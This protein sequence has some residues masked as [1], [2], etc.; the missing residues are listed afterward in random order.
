[1]QRQKPLV[2][3]HR[4]AAG[5][6]PENTLAAFSRA[7]SLG[8][9]AVE[10]DVLMTA[11]DVL[12][13]HHNFTLNPSYSRTSDGTWIPEEG[14]PP[15]R[16]L[17]LEEIKAYDVGRLKPG[18]PETGRYPEQ[19]PCDGERIPTL[20]EVVQRVGSEGGGRVAFWIEI[21]T[22]PEEPEMRPP[23][24]VVARAVV[25]AIRK[26]DIA[27]RSRV[28]SF[29]WRA[30]AH[31]KALAPDLP[32]VYLT[33]GEQRF[34][35]S[36]VAGTKEFPWTD[37]LNIE[38][39]DGSLP[40]MVQAAGGDLWGPNYNLVTPS[41]IEEAHGLGMPVLVWTVDDRAE[42]V[43]MIDMGVDSITTNRPDLFRSL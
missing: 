6:A 16:S 35:R 24:R 13:V 1:M 9:D 38:D 3:G 26:N 12:V 22:S 39:F 14:S 33:A 36:P 32:R 40:R 42:M 41:L 20:D 23:P 25:A 18:S 19:Q 4:G 7:V 31:V 37:G 17:T 5:L 43:R 30:L 27:A 8:V 28:I 15:V 29:D 11:D 34:K 2:I 21:K 10:L